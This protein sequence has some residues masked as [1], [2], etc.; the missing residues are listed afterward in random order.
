M[1][2]RLRELRKQL[3][4]T[5]A[6]L[7]EKIGIT[8]TTISDIERGK[9]TLTNRNISL[10]CEKLGVNESWLR[11]G[12]GDKFNIL[13]LP[14]DELTMALASIEKEKYE[15]VKSALIKYANLDDNGKKIVNDFLELFLS[16]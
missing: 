8:G 6:E 11:F 13:E 5:Q 16:K 4:L 12:S 9:L 7:G 2:Q 3:H 14:I 1:Q 10:L 15:K